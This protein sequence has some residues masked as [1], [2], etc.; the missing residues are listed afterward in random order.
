MKEKLE[1][2]FLIVDWVHKSSIRISIKKKKD[3]EGE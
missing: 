1:E 2:V 3:E